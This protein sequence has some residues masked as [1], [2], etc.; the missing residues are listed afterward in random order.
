MV[1]YPIPER[2]RGRLFLPLLAL[3]V[4]LARAGAIPRRG[5]LE[6][7]AAPD[8]LR[9]LQLARTVPRARAIIAS[10]GPAARQYVSHS[11]RVDCLFL[12]PY[13]TTLGLACVWAG[14]ALRTRQWVGAAL[15]VPLAWGL[16]FAALC[17][18]GENA[19]LLLMLRGPV[20][21]PW[22]Q[23]TWACAVPKRALVTAGLAYP[24]LGLVARLAALREASAG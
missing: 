4:G 15:G 23:V 2:L 21:S 13:S 20:A 6:T 22:P 17:D 3:T 19:G 16:W 8:G 10:W 9:S 5:I 24:A 18:A 11:V 14:D 7:P 12:L 1:R